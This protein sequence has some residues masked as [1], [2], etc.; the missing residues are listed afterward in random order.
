MT[1]KEIVLDFFKLLVAGKIDEGYDKYVDHKGKHHNQ[2]FP[3]GF[4]ALKE[5]MKVN[6]ERFPEKTITVKHALCEGDTVAAHSL[7]TLNPGNIQVAVVHIFRLQDG[8]I[9]EMWDCGM[10]LDDEQ[11]NEDGVF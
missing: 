9:I 7:V 5:G 3:K 6:H 10:P 11:V 8:K 2:H 1:N 4:P